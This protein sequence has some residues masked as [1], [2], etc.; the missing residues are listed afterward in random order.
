MNL[1]LSRSWNLSS[2]G[3]ARLA[4]R[5]EAYNLTNSPQF[6]EPGRNLT[7]PSFGQITNT[8]NQGRVMQAGIRILF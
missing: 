1:A 2:G 3:E 7:S 5:L 4:I 6:D 8:L